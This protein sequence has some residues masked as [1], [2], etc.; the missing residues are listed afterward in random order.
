MKYKKL[1]NTMK[2]NV[3]FYIPYFQHFTDFLEYDSNKLNQKKKESDNL[4][5]NQRLFPSH[6]GFNC[7]IFG[8]SNLVV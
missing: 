1:K 3:D 5:K 6:K 4:M 8:H 7:F 2:K